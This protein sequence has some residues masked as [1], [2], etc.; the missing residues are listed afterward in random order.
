MNNIITI[1]SISL[2]SRLNS[3]HVKLFAVA[4]VMALSIVSCSNN[5]SKRNLRHVNTEPETQSKKAEY[6]SE[7]KKIFSFSNEPVMDSLSHLKVYYVA[8]EY[9]LYNGEEWHIGLAKEIN[10]KFRFAQFDYDFR[11]DRFMVGFVID[12]CGVLVAPRL[13]KDDK[14]ISA[15]NLLEVLRSCE[16][17]TAGKIGGK[18]VNTYLVLD[19][20]F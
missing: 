17:W 16:N 14:T 13:L 20:R 9:P 7:D 11:S 5:S 19:M 10:K 8:D 18:A 2:A 6:Q 3:R 12:S 15:R 1:G 4:S